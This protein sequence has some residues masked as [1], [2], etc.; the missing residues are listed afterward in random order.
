MHDR[1]VAELLYQRLAALNRGIRDLCCLGGAIGSPAAT[2]DAV[3]EGNHATD[4]S[5]VDEGIAHVA[6]RLEVNAEVD[7]VVRTEA[8][9]VQEA[10]E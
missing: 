3:D 10:L 8:D 5:E 4:V 7:E 2:L 1:G 6:A 9:F